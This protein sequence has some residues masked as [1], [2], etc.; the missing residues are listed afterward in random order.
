MKQTM[1][2]GVHTLQFSSDGQYLAFVH[3]LTLR[4]VYLFHVEKLQLSDIIIQ[5]Q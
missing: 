3:G 4:V 1:K 2:T 5:N